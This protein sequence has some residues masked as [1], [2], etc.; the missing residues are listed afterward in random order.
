MGQALHESATTTLIESLTMH[1][2]HGP[3]LGGDSRRLAWMAGAM[4]LAA[5]AATKRVHAGRRVSA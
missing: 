5:S 3:L 1:L 4:M 2:I